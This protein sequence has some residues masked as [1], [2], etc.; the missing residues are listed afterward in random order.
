MATFVK[1]NAVPNASGYELLEKVGEAYN[2]LAT[3]SDINFEVSAMEFE[4][5]DHLLAVKA[6]G[7]GVNY[8]DSDPSETVT[9]TVEDEDWVDITDQF[10]FT[11][12]GMISAN[13]GKFTTYSGWVANEEYVDLSAYSEIEIKMS[14]TS[15]TA[16]GTGLA[17]YDADKNFVSGIPHTDGV[18]SYGTM[19]KNITLAA[20]M[21]YIRT[22]YWSTSNANYKT[23]FGDFYCKAKKKS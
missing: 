9:Y 1:G 14:K 6:K 23:E 10:D 19:I 11:E 13:D 2:A 12:S 4:P 20:N 5:G 15:S 22:T 21:V 18:A 3:A 8:S 17:F 7:D 16:T